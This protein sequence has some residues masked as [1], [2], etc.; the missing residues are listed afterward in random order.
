MREGNGSRSIITNGRAAFRLGAPR[1]GPGHVAEAIGVGEKS[2]RLTAEW[3]VNLGLDLSPESHDRITRAIHKAVLSEIA[4]ID[5][6]NPISLDLRGPGRRVPGML[7]GIFPTDP[8]T[9]L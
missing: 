7:D 2:D 6:A 3:T 8:E 1:P 9:Q 5:E 4:E